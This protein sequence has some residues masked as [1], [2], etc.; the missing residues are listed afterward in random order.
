M[1]VYQH[2]GDSHRR[3]LDARVQLTADLAIRRHYGSCAQLVT[4][5]VGGHGAASLTRLDISKTTLCSQLSSHN[6]ALALPVHCLGDVIV[7]NSTQLSDQLPKSRI[8]LASRQQWLATGD[9]VLSKVKVEG[10]G[11]VDICLV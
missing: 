10:K 4:L 8:F 7:T 6:T 9:L 5:P 2:C 11:R 1:P 3:H